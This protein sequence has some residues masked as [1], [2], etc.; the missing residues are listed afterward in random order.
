VLVGDT[1]RCEFLKWERR[2]FVEKHVQ[3]TVVVREVKGVEVGEPF[4]EAT[5]E[6]AC[7][8]FDDEWESTTVDDGEELF[9]NKRK[10]IQAEALVFVFVDE[11]EDNFPTLIR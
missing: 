7:C 4:E 2:D 1:K 8:I 10:I 3:V 6:R 5:E 9:G 11:S